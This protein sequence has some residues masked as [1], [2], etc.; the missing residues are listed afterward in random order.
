MRAPV[1][2]QPHS[3]GAP[4][5]AQPCCLPEH[6]QNSPRS[7]SDR[8]PEDTERR[9][10]AL[11]QAQGRKYRRAVWT[12]PQ[13]TYVPCTCLGKCS[14]LMLCITAWTT[15]AFKPMRI[16][17]WRACTCVV[18]YV[19]GH[20]ARAYVLLCAYMCVHGLYV[21]VQC[22]YITDYIHISHT[23]I[24]ICVHLCKGHVHTPPY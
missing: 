14:V 13:S 7:V 24:C 1:W 8:H 9:D 19:C 23:C 21:Y 20:E 6:K 11:G 3:M 5:A 22:A 17:A 10:D 18:I 12:P 2:G 16:Y 4:S 15:H